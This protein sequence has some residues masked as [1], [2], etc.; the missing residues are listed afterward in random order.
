MSYTN[1]NGDTLS[2]PVSLLG[3]LPNG[4]PLT[5][6]LVSPNPTIDFS[7]Y[8]H[9]GDQYLPPSPTAINPYITPLAQTITLL[10]VHNSI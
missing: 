8:F 4:D 9:I 10:A 2:P 7:L 1:E 6:Y 5:D 3:E